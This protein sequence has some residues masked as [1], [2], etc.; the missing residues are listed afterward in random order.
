MKI[1]A[2][3]IIKA[4]PWRSGKYKKDWVYQQWAVE[5]DTLEECFKKIYRSERSNRYCN[6]RYIRVIPDSINEAYKAWKVHGVT[7]EMYYGNGTV[8]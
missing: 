2:Q 3:T 1:E 5:A 7:I 6:D 8:D 4:E